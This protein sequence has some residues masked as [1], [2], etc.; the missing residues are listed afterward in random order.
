VCRVGDG[1]HQS[2]HVLTGKHCALAFDTTLVKDAVQSGEMT[3]PCGGSG[4]AIGDT[5]TRRNPRSML[6]AD[7]TKIWIA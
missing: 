1:K 3:D 2:T 7:G 4:G 5:V 6:G